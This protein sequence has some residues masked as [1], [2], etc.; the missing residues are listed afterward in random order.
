MFE[1][2]LD[3]VTHTEV[4][5]DGELSIK[6]NI[7]PENILS[8]IDEVKF[9]QDN[10]EIVITIDSPKF[11]FQHNYRVRYTQD[12]K[13]I[14]DVYFNSARNTEE[15]EELDAVIRVL[16]DKHNDYIRSMEKESKEKEEKEMSEST[17][18]Q[19]N[20]SEFYKNKIN[21]KVGIRNLKIGLL[22]QREDS[23]RVYLFN[24]VKTILYNIKNLSFS[25]LDNGE[26]IIKDE[27][28]SIG[29]IKKGN[30]HDGEILYLNVSY[31]EIEDLEGKKITRHNRF[32][33]AITDIELIEDIEECIHDAVK[34]II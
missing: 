6:R 26:K 23:I 13:V 30:S 27:Q 4:K 8:R 22:E 1:E 14:L 32:N 21:K 28:S 18:S 33:M 2:I 29:Y 11:T 34:R 16:V 17:H 10:F 15:K 7:Y 9:I 20:Y 12:N 24:K 5:K 3:L 31:Q 25:N 19:F